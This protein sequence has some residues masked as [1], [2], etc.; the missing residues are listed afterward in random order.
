MRMP[1]GFRKVGHI[2]TLVIPH[3]AHSSWSCV[4][5]HSHVVHI[6]HI[7][8]AIFVAS[9]NVCMSRFLTLLS[10]TSSTRLD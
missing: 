10:L 4:K 9:T 3:H 6:T 5:F 7:R 8:N 1:F 2:F